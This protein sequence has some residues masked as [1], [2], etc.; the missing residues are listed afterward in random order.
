MGPI[1]NY[2]EG[3]GNFLGSNTRIGIADSANYHHI[4]IQ[5][6][7]W[8]FNRLG[9]G[10][11]TDFITGSL[12]L[13]ILAG[14]NIEFEEV[15]DSQDIK[16]YFRI[17][18]IQKDWVL[19][20]NIGPTLSD[21]VGYDLNLTEQEIA[22]KTELFVEIL[23]AVPATIEST[24]NR[25]RIYF[26]E[27]ETSDPGTNIGISGNNSYVAR[28][29]FYE[30]VEKGFIN[31]EVQSSIAENIPDHTRGTK[32]YKQWQDPIYGDYYPTEYIEKF[33]LLCTG[34]DYLAAGSRIRIY[35]R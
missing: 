20:R 19:L 3:L 28:H 26:T 1:D 33:R 30:K 16:R 11:G 27:P 22:D 21:E 35:A 2:Y 7:E 32:F 18:H 5:D 9:V 15:K 23:A 31:I 34:T 8:R 4:I 29:T 24:A 17:N 14:K 13:P 12:H 10:T 6:F 25:F